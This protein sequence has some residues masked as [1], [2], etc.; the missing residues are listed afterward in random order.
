MQPEPNE[1]NPRNYSLIIGL[2]IPILMILFVAGAIYLPR[3]FI[4]VEPAEFDFLY[5][6]GQRGAYTNYLVREERLVRE[7]RAIPENV[8]QPQPE[9]QFF[10]HEVASNTSREITFSEAQVLYLDASAIAQDGYRIERGRRGGWFPFDYS[11]NYRKRYLVK[12][13][14]SEELNLALDNSSTYN[15]ANF[16]FLGWVTK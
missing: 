6:T 16:R 13:H 1:S 4:T 9:P 15:Y 11:Y 10:I 5:T 3:W 8:S 2:S 14:F 12:G 7:D